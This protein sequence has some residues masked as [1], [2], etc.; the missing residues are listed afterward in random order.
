M[1][2]SGEAGER[3][4]PGCPPWVW[5]QNTEGEGTQASEPGAGELSATGWKHFINI[6]VWQEAG[7]HICDLDC[8]WCSV[9]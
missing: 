9:S 4:S 6:M 7:G 1:G 2:R 8:T 3:C 5:G